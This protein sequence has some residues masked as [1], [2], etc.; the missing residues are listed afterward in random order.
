MSRWQCLECLKARGKAKRMVVRSV[1]PGICAKCGAQIRASE[2]LDCVTRRQA[3]YGRR[4]LEQ[5]YSADYVARFDQLPAAER[6]R[7]FRNV[8][9][10]PTSRLPALTQLF[11]GLEP[12][13]EN[14]LKR[15]K[16]EKDMALCAAVAAIPAADQRGYLERALVDRAQADRWAA[17]HSTSGRSWRGDEDDKRIWHFS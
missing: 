17:R 13:V 7:I 8:Y 5:A 3:A 15:E 6:D 1:K 14:T 12:W 16:R 9:R 4:K 2:C 11:P 10:W